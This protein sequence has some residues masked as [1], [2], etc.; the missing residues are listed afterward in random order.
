MDF[1]QSHT[2]MQNI[3][4]KVICTK[5]NGKIKFY[6]DDT[7]NPFLKEKKDVTE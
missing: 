6:L 3:S 4:K 2:I 1:E 5:V 7:Y